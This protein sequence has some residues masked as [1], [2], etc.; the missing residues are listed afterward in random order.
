MME[1]A[2]SLTQRPAT[3]LLDVAARRADFPV[4]HQLVHGKPLV[5]LD[6]AASAQTPQSVI[7]A[8]VHFYR[9]DYANV[10]RGV[11]ILSQRATESYEHARGVVQGFINAEHEREVIFTKGTTEGINLVA[12]GFGERYVTAGDEIVVSAMEHH[13]NIVPWQLMCK[14]KGAIL[15][16]I[17]MDDCGELCLDALPSLLGPKTRLVSVVHV[18]NALGTVNPVEEIIAMAHARG[19]PVLLDG[20]QA[21]PHQ[22]V[23]VMALDADFY[24]FSGHK[25]Y[26]PTGVGVLYGKSEYLDALPPYHGGGD[27]IA[28]VT[29]E[30]TLFREIP[31]KFE[32]GTPNVA[33]VIG[34]GAALEYIERVGIERIAQHEATLLHYATERLST[35]PLARVIGTAKKKAGVLSFNL[36]G[37]H[38]H[39]VGTILDRL[40]VAIRVGH[41]CAQPVM[42]HYGIPS[43]ARASFGMYNTLEEIDCFVDALHRVVEVFS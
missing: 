32:A 16:V 31:H 18:S 1:N 3:D 36:D 23:D 37:I 29:F 13:S 41:H 22:R 40:G 14:R 33:G 24:V 39:D 6:N 12:F 9:N 5:Y 7:D 20:A 35:I 2:E 43:T 25:V 28:R 26:G 10:H 11:H 4:L 8:I 38:S 27:M 42:A 17:P 21:A 19:I 34:L 30:E 15:R